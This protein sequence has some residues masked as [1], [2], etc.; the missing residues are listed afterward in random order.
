MI[1]ADLK[2]L[3]VHAAADMLSANEISSL[4][5]CNA[6]IER[7]EKVDSQV[8][9]FLKLDK[10]DILKR[11]ADADARRADGKELSPYDGIPIGIKD[12]I[13]TEKQTCSCAS[14][15]LENVV[16]PYDSTVVA[17]LKAKGFIPAGRLNMDEFA[18]GS[19]CENSAFQKTA[20]PWD[21]KRVPGGSSG[22]SAA[23]V[24]AGEVP[25]SLGSDTGGS[26]R[27]PAAFCG[28]VGL[29]PTYGRVSRYGLVAFAS[30]LDQIGPLSHDVLDSAIILDTIGG[31]DPKDSTSLPEPCTGFADALKDLEDKDL[32]GV[33]VGL[34]KEYFDTEGISEGVRKGLD[35]T[36]ATLKKLGAEI[37]EVS[38]PHTKYAV[39]VYYVIATAEASANLARFDGVRYG[40][41]KDGGDLIAT[42]FKSRGEGF[43]DEVQRRILLG[44]YVLSSG[45]YD[46]YYL[47]AQKVRTLIRRDFEEAA[48]Q[49]DILLTPVTTAPAFKFGAK[50]DPL[51]MYLSDIFTIA[52]NLSGACGISLPAGI[53]E[54]NKIPVAIQFIAPALEEAKLFRIA[55][56][57]E[58]NRD[59]KE[60]APEL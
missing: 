22:G 57:F 27:Q 19:S 28:V 4:E 29:K 36:I 9:A 33:K 60:F 26:I 37:V 6:Y 12:C 45:Y 43:G 44:T 47:R 56:I 42:Y 11:A 23:C 30:S 24:A 50:S 40:V 10:N 18:M 21:L 46:A 14:K 3:T 5:L 38:L 53:S 34:P 54:A 20:N 35:D 13:V 51:Q 49:C 25:V 17:R 31:L 15:L 41:R 58:L 55:R 8:K 1:K 52:L 48:K 32:N 2:T 16:S 59:Q 7:I 39:S